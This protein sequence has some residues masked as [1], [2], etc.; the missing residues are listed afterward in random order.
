VTSKEKNDL[1][2]Q[3]CRLNAHQVLK[4]SAKHPPPSV[5]SGN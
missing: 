3:L 1:N 2:Q 4:E 5:F